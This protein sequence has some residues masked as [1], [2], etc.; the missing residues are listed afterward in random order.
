MGAVNSEDG[1]FCQMEKFEKQVWFFLFFFF[2]GG[3]KG[4]F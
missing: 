2:L 3:G 1:D 4:V